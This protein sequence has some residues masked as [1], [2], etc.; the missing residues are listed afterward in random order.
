MMH[1]LIL[2]AIVLCIFI[3]K[4]MLYKNGASEPALYYAPC[5]VIFGLCIIHYRKEIPNNLKYSWILFI[6]SCIVPIIILLIFPSNA[7]VAAY[8]YVSWDAIICGEESPIHPTVTSMV[9]STTARIIMFSFIFIYVYSHW[10]LK[11]Y[12]WLIDRLAHIANLFIILGVIEFILK[13][14]LMQ[15]ALWGDLSLSFFGRTTSTVYAGRLR[16]GLYELTLFTKEAAT[17]AYSLFVVLLIKMTDNVV[18]G[19]KLFDKYMITAI[20]LLLLSTSFSSLY[21]LTILIAIVLL[22]KYYVTHIKTIVFYSLLVGALMLFLINFLSELP[23]FQRLFNIVDN[24]NYY[25]SMDYMGR[26]RSMSDGSS[27]I[28]LTSVFQ[29]LKAFAQRPLFGYSAG[30]VSCHGSTAAFFASV[31]LIGVFYWVRFHFFAMSLYKEIR[32]LCKPYFFC[33]ILFILFHLFSGRGIDPY[34]IISLLVFPTCFC[35]MFKKKTSQQLVILSKN[36]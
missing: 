23:I 20:G 8:P 35:L 29:T 9:I 27:F 3:G 14:I 16:G 31:G 6:I 11:D 22:Y 18:K 33:I 2:Y 24:Y 13:N 21:E 32:P 36:E 12:Y 1:N 4:G 7:W 17:F 10:Q 30:S 34:Y 26:D 25:F 19:K 28:R 5:M 15:N